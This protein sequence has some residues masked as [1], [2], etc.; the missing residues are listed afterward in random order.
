MTTKFRWIVCTEVG[1]EVNAEMNA[2]S[3]R[4][5]N[6]METYREW[7][8]ARLR[9]IHIDFKGV[10]WWVRYE[11]CYQ[12]VIISRYPCEFD[13]SLGVI[14]KDVRWGPS[15]SGAVNFPVDGGW[16][17]RKHWRKW[18]ANGQHSVTNVRGMN[19]RGDSMARESPKRALIWGLIAS[20][21]NWK[22]DG[23]RSV[24][25][26][27]KCLKEQNFRFD[28]DEEVGEPEYSYWETDNED[29][30][31]RSFKEFGAFRRNWKWEMERLV[32]Y[33]EVKDV[34]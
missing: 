31:V 30:R 7:E 8:V 29:R 16:Q 27:R 20:L 14:V 12:N 1:A 22:R 23:L 15:V 4:R 13:V 9:D 34:N 18:V 25:R 32:S 24:F 28:F 19:D 6:E 2:E 5:C 11:K 3:E 33:R 21:K 17:M 26:K 10:G